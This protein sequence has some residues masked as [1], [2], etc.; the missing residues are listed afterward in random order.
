MK[1]TEDAVQVYGGYEFIKDHPVENLM[2]DAKIMQLYEGTS[3]IQ[4]LVIARETLPPHRPEAGSPNEVAP[5]SGVSWEQ[6]RRRL[7]SSGRSL[8]ALVAPRPSRCGFQ[9]SFQ[10]PDLCGDD[11]C[12]VAVCGTHVGG[13]SL[14]RPFSDSTGAPGCPVSFL[15]GQPVVCSAPNPP[16]TQLLR[17]PGEGWIR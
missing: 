11:P 6:G 7:V 4:R 15:I 5:R 16:D 1:V 17:G 9:L 8:G 12:E 10:S 2:R 3:H 13:S 14:V